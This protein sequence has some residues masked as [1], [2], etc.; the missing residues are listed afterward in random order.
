MGKKRFHQSGAL[1]LPRKWQ[2]VVVLAWLKRVHAWTGFWGAALFLLLGVTGVLLNHKSVWKIDTGQPEIVSAM[3]VPVPAGSIADQPA[4]GR[5]AQA[6]F[7]LTSVPSPAR[8]SSPARTTKTLLGREYT[9][10]ETWTLRFFHPN[11]RVTVE[12]IK[13]SNSV[14]VEQNR[15]NVWGFIKNLHKST[16]AQLAWVLFMDMIAGALILMSLTGFLLWTRLHGPRLL[17]G[18]IVMGSIVTA[19]AAVW[20][21]ML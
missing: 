17:A 7:G 19:T 9:E 18:A 21:T 11:G 14:W 10:A 3:A 6:E 8:S 13:G 2:R 12:H 16:G 15:Q 4:L 20:P 1:F 5:W